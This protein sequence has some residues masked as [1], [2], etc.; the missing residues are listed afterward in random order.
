MYTSF[1]FSFLFQFTWQSSRM[2]NQSFP[3]QKELLLLLLL[4]AVSLEFSGFIYR[5]E[6]KHLSIQIP[7]LNDTGEIGAFFFSIF[8]L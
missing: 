8:R 6:T 1:Y 5:Y 2:E 4:R 7:V 3:L